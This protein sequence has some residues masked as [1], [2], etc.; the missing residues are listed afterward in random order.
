M[1]YIIKILYYA[2]LILYIF[3][4]IKWVKC[5]CN[6]L[7]AGIKDSFS[8]N[9]NGDFHS[10]KE[11]FERQCRVENTISG[12]VIAVSDTAIKLTFHYL[13]KEIYYTHMHTHTTSGSWIIKIVFQ[14]MKTFLTN[15]NENLDTHNTLLT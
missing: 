4:I 12:T 11:T 3:I 9:Y 6:M 8:S 13:T 5:S 14:Y 10:T 1:N 15:K 7:R 2:L